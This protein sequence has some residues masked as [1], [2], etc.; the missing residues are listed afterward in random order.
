ML[1][2]SLQMNTL[3][4]SIL[5]FAITQVLSADEPISFRSL[6][7]TA[8]KEEFADFLGSPIHRHI[9]SDSQLATV[10]RVQA[11]RLEKD[12][13]IETLPYSKAKVLTDKIEVVAKELDTL[14][15]LL[16]DR[17]SF[18]GAALEKCC[19][20]NGD[21]RIDFSSHGFEV[22]FL[23][24]TS[25]TDIAV[26]VEDTF[27]GFAP[28]EPC[29]PDLYKLLKR[30]FPDDGFT[31]KLSEDNSR[32]I[33]LIQEAVKGDQFNDP[34]SDDYRKVKLPKREQDGAGQPATAP[35]SKPEGGSKSKPE[36]KG[37]SQ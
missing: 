13:M 1:R 11:I 24:C 27:I 33:K 17:H 21:Y 20:F 18:G 25:C 30:V 6:G 9:I 10:Y 3:R 22:S 26:Y 16:L 23:V 2:R 15:R 7:V 31:Q 5:I 37:R 34:F 12:G 28:F 29:Q 14:R 4:I 8:T 32:V 35:E 19:G 36:S